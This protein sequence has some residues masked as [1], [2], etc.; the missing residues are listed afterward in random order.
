[1]AE[2]E[3]R[4]AECPADQQEALRT[5]AEETRQRQSTIDESIARARTGVEKLRLTEEL[6]A[7]NLAMVNE[8]AGRLRGL[9]E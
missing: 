4:I 8:A 7:M 3:A 1:M 6:A 9:G 5:L 2:L